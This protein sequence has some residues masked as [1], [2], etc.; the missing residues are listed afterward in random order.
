MGY[1][2]HPGWSDADVGNV[3]D[4]N[5]LLPCEWCGHEERWE[6]IRENGGWLKSNHPDVPMLCPSCRN[7][8]EENNDEVD[9]L[10]AEM[11][12]RTMTQRRCI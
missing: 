10:L 5:P 11:D 8:W 9:Q 3:P 4:R 1:R 12:C 6:E 2:G 7:L